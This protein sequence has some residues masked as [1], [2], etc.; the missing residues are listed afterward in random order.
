MPETT[1]AATL[2]YQISDHG[3]K[4]VVTPV[5]YFDTKGNK[6]KVKLD[7][8]TGRL[9]IKPR[10][11]PRPKDVGPNTTSQIF[12]GYIC[13]PKKADWSKDPVV[14]HEG[15]VGQLLVIDIAKVPEAQTTPFVSQYPSKW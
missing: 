1:A 9:M 8:E 6:A 14:R 7:K 4:F 15:P 3:D 13:L 2:N 5:C 11:K 10:S 12:G